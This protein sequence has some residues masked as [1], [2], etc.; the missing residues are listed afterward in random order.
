MAFAKRDGAWLGVAQLLGKWDKWGG[1]SELILGS[2]GCLHTPGIATGCQPKLF[3]GLLQPWGLLL[4]LAV[5]TSMA[6]FGICMC[7]IVMLAVVD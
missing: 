5:R 4:C 3:N 7:E 1:V 6:S 2:G